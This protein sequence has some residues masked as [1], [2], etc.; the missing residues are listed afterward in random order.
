MSR[1]PCSSPFNMREEGQ[2]WLPE[3]SLAQSTAHLPLPWPSDLIPWA[4]QAV[5]S[6]VM[7][8]GPPA[9]GGGSR[10]SHSVLPLARPLTSGRTACQCK[11]P[12]VWL[13]GSPAEPACPQTHL[14]LC[15]EQGHTQ[16]QTAMPNPEPGALKAQ[17]FSKP[18]TSRNAVVLASAFCS[19]T[20]DSGHHQP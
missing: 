10:G 2:T 4:K 5:P 19:S 11:C 1:K 17:F 18:L 13:P 8:G 14:I 9:M 6:V 15:R 12:C 3:P 7:Q 20:V 16:F